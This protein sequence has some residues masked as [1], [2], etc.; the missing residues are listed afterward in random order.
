MPFGSRT[1]NI[2][3]I[4]TVVCVSMSC[5]LGVVGQV[6]WNTKNLK[7]AVDLQEKIV[8]QQ[9]EMLTILRHLERRYLDGAPK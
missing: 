8:D 5:V 6:L 7:A 2:W 3:F 1:N 4:V 9:H